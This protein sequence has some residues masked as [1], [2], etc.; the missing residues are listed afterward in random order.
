LSQ[1]IVI[2]YNPFSL[3]I[4]VRFLYSKQSVYYVD[5]AASLEFYFV[6]DCL[7]FRGRET[8]LIYLILHWTKFIIGFHKF[9]VFPLELFSGGV[10]N[11]IMDH[12]KNCCLSFLP[13][14]TS[15]SSHT[16]EARDLKF[17]MHNPYTNASKD[18]DQIFDILAR[19]WDIEVQSYAVHQGGEW[20][21]REGNKSFII[22][23]LEKNKIRQQTPS[24]CSW[25]WSHLVTWIIKH[26]SIF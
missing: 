17:G 4:L 14:A 8:T 11:S 26:Q 6:S 16:I 1:L 24:S 20:V 12:S 3:V 7:S 10:R 9:F 21:Y 2:T 25:I 15:F 18:T 23:T 22:W 19:S 5:G 13:S